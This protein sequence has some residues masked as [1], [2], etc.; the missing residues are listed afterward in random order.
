[1]KHLEG[2]LG[3]VEKMRQNSEFV[4]REKDQFIVAL[5]QEMHGL[6]QELKTKVVLPTQ[7]SV[8]VCIPPHC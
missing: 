6:R 1:L 5:H 4:C 7:G 2:K 8:P 3:Y